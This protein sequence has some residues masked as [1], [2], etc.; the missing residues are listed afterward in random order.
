MCG[1]DTEG[2]VGAE[3]HER[4]EAAGVWVLVVG[5]GGVM[6]FEV[7]SERETQPI[8][9]YCSYPEMMGLILVSFFF[10]WLV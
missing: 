3:R 7:G 10:L 4:R 9:H 1:G 5:G 8:T 2:S 6:D